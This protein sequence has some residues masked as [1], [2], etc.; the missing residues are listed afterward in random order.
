MNPEYD[1]GSLL[2][3]SEYMQTNPEDF[4][5]GQV[6]ALG[7]AL[8]RVHSAAS[9]ALEP[10]KERLRMDAFTLL[11][12]QAPNDRQV[13]FEPSDTELPFEL[14]PDERVVVTFPTAIP[15]LKKSVNGD[16]LRELLTPDVFDSYFTTRVSYVT[17]KSL[18]ETANARVALGALEEVQTLLEH[19]ESPEPTPRVSFKLGR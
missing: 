2:S 6:A 16:D 15:R 9:R 8:A 19:L 5:P 14:E 12:N 3:L 11:A 17:R 13:S 18:S 10:L 7:L 4:S 1:I